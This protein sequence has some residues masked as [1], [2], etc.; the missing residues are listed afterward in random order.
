MQKINPENERTKR[1]YLTYLKEAGRLSEASVDQAAAAIDRFAAYNRQRSFK[2]FH[3]EQA[4]GF[5]RY[6]AKQVNIKN[7]TPLSK[8]T[9]Y[10]ILTAV[11]NFFIW[12]ADRPGYRSR[13]RYADAEYFNLSEKETR[14]AKTHREPRMPLL[15]QI[16][17][18]V[19]SM[20][21]GTDVE[22]RDRALLASTILTGARDSALASLKLRHVDLQRGCVY[23]DAREVRTKFSKT[24]TTFFFPIGDVFRQMLADWVRELLASYAWGADDPLFPATRIEVRKATGMFEACGLLRQHWS[25]AAPVRR[26]FRQAFAAVDLP[27][28]NPHSFRRTLAIEGQRRCRSIEELK[29]WSQ[30]LGHEGMLTTLTSY[31]QIPIAR[32]AELIGR[33]GEADEASGDADLLRKIQKLVNS[34]ER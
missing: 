31:G 25:T 5:K 15:P 28:F 14:I 24:I 34:S 8:A 12:L 23:Q 21:A 17:R 7:G 26:I 29:A 32:Q 1:A 16:E 11:K 27:Y 4:S 33:I 9:L 20:P 22:R 3:I 30:N 6:L 19:T 10:A 18:V 13:I 2:A